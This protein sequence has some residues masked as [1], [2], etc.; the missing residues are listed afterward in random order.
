MHVRVSMVNGASDIDRGMEFVRDEVIPQ[1]QQQK[2]FRGLA[3]SANREERVVSILTMWDSEADLD[4]SESMADKARG[5]AV[6]VIGGQATVERYE[7]VAWELGSVPPGPGAKLHVRHIR[8][9]P[10]TCDDN[11][12]VFQREVVPELQATPGFLGVRLL[13]DR[14]TGE[15]RVG[16]VWADEE[17][18]RGSLVRAEERRPVA[19][20]HGVEF[21]QEDFFDVLLSTP[22]NR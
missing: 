18:R 5:D 19:Q 10:S 9:D 17:A 6:K 22:M 12:A 13:I 16:T 14:R 8:M 7:Q 1:L 2:G 11:V 15:G 20:S 4:A 3:S 21:G